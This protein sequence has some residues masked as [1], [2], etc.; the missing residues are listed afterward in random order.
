[1]AGPS[2]AR[3]LVAHLASELLD[4]RDAITHRLVERIHSSGE[5][6]VDDSLRAATE[7]AG[8]RIVEQLLAQLRDGDE[9]ARSM[10]PEAAIAYAHEYAHRGID[11]PVLLA[12]VRSGYAEFSSQWSR[13]FSEE[14]PPTRASLEALSASLLD[15]FAYVD[16]ISTAFVVAYTDERARW[17]RSVESLRLDV[18]RTILG[19][20]AVD[21]EVA[22]QR[23]GQRLDTAHR[24]FVVWSDSEPTLGVR[25][26]LEAA[27]RELFDRAG[28][29]HRLI[30][31]LTGQLIAGWISGVSAAIDEAS[32]GS[33]PL[34]ALDGI[35]VKAA[36]GL[37]GDGIAGFRSSH[38]QALHAQRVARALGDG[39]DDVTAY[40]EVGLLA[41]ASVDLEHAAEFVSEELG[42]LAAPDGATTKIANTVRIYLDEGRSRAR[43]ARR[44]ELHTNTIAYRLM[45]AAELLGHELDHRAAEVAVAL[46][47]LPLTRQ[48][49]A[50]EP[51]A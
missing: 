34:T 12:V 38:R 47:I 6:P 43:T 16:S 17:S 18:V 5:F 15:I 46:S 37:P 24:A 33:Q 39:A 30:V 26:A 1:M 7:E 32:L 48:L 29:E 31:P 51:G 45:R 35:D 22:S 8:A 44:L 21:P 14:E 23:L 41:L 25:G 28:T 9:M 2:H 4:E 13:R 50:R 20:D 36:L 40:S 19:G 10:P 11:L 3:P 42:A 49:P 27:C